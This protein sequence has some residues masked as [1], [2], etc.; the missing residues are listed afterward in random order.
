M[1]APVTMHLL[2]SLVAWLLLTPAQPADI[3][4]SSDRYEVEALHPGGDDRPARVII[5]D[6]RTSRR[7]ILSI[8]ST[9]GALR[10]AVIRADQG[11]IVF[12]LDKGFAVVDPEG[13]ALTDEVYALDPLVSPEGRWVAARRFAPATHP[14]P[15]DGVLLYDTAAPAARNHGAYPI[16][17]ER[18]WRAGVAVYPPSTEWK[19]ASASIPAE[20]AVVLTAPLSWTTGADSASLLVFGARRGEADAVIVADPSG[21]AVRVCAERLPGP[22]ADWRVKTIDVDRAAPGEVTVRVRSGAARADAPQAAFSLRLQS[23]AEAR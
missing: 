10:R 4:A 23:C 1:A 17:A 14:A 7:H 19:E 5:S 15:S 13:R 9:L 22:A 18:E 16:P 3:R 20:D 8:N 21:D 2:A 6:A 12:V 11:R